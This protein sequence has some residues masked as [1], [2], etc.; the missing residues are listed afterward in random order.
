MGVIYILIPLALGVMIAA[1]VTFWWAARDGQFDDMDTPA[2]RV[3]FE[4]GVRQ[5][6]AQPAAP[7]HPAALSKNPEHNRDGHPSVR[8]EDRV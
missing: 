8:R 5:A 1:V 4:D 7:G 2:L 6:G 3:L